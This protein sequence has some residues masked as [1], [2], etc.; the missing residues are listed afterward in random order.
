MNRKIVGMT[1]AHRT[2]IWIGSTI[3]L[4]ILGTLLLFRWRTQRP[5]SLRG[6]VSVKDADRR[7]EQPIADV[8]VTSDLATGT[9]KSD[10]TGFFSLELRGFVRRGQPLVLHF[11][12]PH[13]LPLD[14]SDFVGDKLYVVHMVPLCPSA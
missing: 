3:I 8:E 10:S 7:K 9:A 14:L 12:Q 5:V 1:R 2:E 4:M 6:A 13:Y 11:R